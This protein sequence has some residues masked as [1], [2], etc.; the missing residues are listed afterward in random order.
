MAKVFGTEGRYLELQR[1][2]RTVSGIDT[3][4]IFICVGFTAKSRANILNHS[5]HRVAKFSVQVFLQWISFRLLPLNCFL[6][7]V[8][9]KTF[10]Y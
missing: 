6:G 9:S 4:G 10:E 7:A 1:G 5:A 8:W 2:T 3:L